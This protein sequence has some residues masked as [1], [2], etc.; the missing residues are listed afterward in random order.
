MR[1]HWHDPGF[2]DHVKAFEVFMS[3]HPELYGNKYIAPCIENARG[4]CRSGGLA[5]SF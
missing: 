5:F 1:T 3:K 2:T 4:H